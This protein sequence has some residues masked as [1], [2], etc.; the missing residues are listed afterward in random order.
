MSLDLLVALRVRDARRV[1]RRDSRSLSAAM[2]TH[3][4]SRHQVLLPTSTSYRLPR[5]VAY[6]RLEGAAAHDGL[7]AQPARRSA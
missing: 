7:H 5:V 3:T 1:L 6:N 2:A 4:S